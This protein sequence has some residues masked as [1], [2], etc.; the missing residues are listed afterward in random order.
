M[1]LKH[2][3]L[4]A[5]LD[6]LLRRGRRTNRAL[7]RILENQEF[8]MGKQEEVLAEITA[9]T[10]AIDTLRTETAELAAAGRAAIA[11]QGEIIAAQ[12]ATI[13]D[14]AAKLDAAI[15]NGFSDEALAE[16][17][18]AAAAAVAGATQAKDDAD[19]VEA[20]FDAVAPAPVEPPADPVA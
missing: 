8:I 9:L 5:V 20:E 16:V 4:G 6:C 13:T 1:S 18:A 11:R 7:A 17:K 10:G 2:F 12:G 14:F 19:T 3:T 15:A